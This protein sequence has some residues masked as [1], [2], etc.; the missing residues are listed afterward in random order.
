MHQKQL[1]SPALW[2]W[3]MRALAGQAAVLQTLQNATRSGHGKGTTLVFST[4][5]TDPDQAGALGQADMSQG[6][7]VGS[8]V[9]YFKIKL[10]S[11]ISVLFNIWFENFYFQSSWQ[12][13]NH[14]TIFDKEKHPCLSRPV[15]A[16]R[17]SR[18]WT[19]WWKAVFYLWHH[20]A[21]YH[22]QSSKMQAMLQNYF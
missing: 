8:Q 6:F 18:T 14:P 3:Q 4:A 9:M 13:F 20:P 5:V 15:C 7:L 10:D 22:D 17:C 11:E 1:F 19:F 12:I 21:E 2:T 16:S